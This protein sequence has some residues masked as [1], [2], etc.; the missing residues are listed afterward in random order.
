MFSWPNLCEEPRCYNSSSVSLPSTVLAMA[1]RLLLV[2]KPPGQIRYGGTAGGAL[3]SAFLE[4]MEEHD[5][6]SIL[7]LLEHLRERLAQ[8][9]FSQVPQLASS[10]V[11]NLKQQFSLTTVARQDTISSICNMYIISIFIFESTILLFIT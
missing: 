11:L 7:D 8:G 2:P 3:T 9:G 10:L 5:D 1:S 6:L 4:A